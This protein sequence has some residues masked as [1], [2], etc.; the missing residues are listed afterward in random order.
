MQTVAV[1]Q[2]I[3]YGPEY[4]EALRKQLPGVVILGDDRPL[5]TNFYGWHSKIELFAP[6]NADLR[7]CLYVDLDTF[8][9]GDLAVFDLLDDTK[10]WLIDDFNRPDIGETGVMVIPEDTTDIWLQRNQMHGTDGEYLRE[11]EHLRLNRVVSGI[12]S[13]KLHCTPDYVPEDAR[14]VCFHGKPKQADLTEGWGYELW[15]TLK[16]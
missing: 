9:L 16:T 6:W 14:I 13:Y 7:P 2:G 11:F 3:K 4:S 10:L 12:Y 8:I 15:N 1:R 5:M